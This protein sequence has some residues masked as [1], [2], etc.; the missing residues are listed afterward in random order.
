[1]NT[2]IVNISIPG[3]LLKEVEQVAKE[4]YRTRSELFREA[5]RDY[6]MNR[7]KLADIY[8][9]AENQAQKT[10]IANANLENIISDYRKNK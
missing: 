7:K 1:M 8:S 5:L 9:Y 10:K 2:K 6:M 4:E 3:P